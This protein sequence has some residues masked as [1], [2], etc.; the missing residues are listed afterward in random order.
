MQGDLVRRRGGKK[1]MRV[2]TLGAPLRGD[3][4]RK[5]NHRFGREYQVLRREDG[6]KSPLPAGHRG[7]MRGLDV[8][9]ASGTDQRLF[10]ACTRKQHAAFLERLA[11]GGHS[12][13]RHGRIHTVLWREHR[14]VDGEVVILGV[15]PS[16]RKHQRTRMNITLV[17]THD[18]EYFHAVI[19]VTQQHHS[20]R[21]QRLRN[22]IASHGAN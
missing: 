14:R 15:H 3:P 5:V 12:Q 4:I 2:E 17:M 18:H 7:A 11:H 13:C 1:E 9:Q 16:A 22:Q 10:P 8:A 6:A 19:T 20:C 21:R